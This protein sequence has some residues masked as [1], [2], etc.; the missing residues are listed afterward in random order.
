MAQ[1]QHRLGTVLERLAKESKL[2]TSIT[3][4]AVLERIGLYG[5]GD[6]FSFGYFED[7]DAI[8][9]FIKLISY[10]II[11]SDQVISSMSHFIF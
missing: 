4:L 6:P 8:E 7:P 11:A 9:N 10:R 2:A 1:Q 5:V 3:E